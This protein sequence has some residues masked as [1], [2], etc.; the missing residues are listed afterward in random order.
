ME[1]SY[2]TLYD[3]FI[4]WLVERRHLW[5]NVSINNNVDCTKK[6]LNFVCFKSNKEMCYLFDDESAWKFFETK[7]FSH[8]TSQDLTEGL[9]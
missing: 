5:K 6:G 1:Q 2:T 3:A 7:V 4:C 9:R 8:Q